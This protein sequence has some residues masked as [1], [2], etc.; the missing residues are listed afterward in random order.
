MNILRLYKCWNS[1]ITVKS[2]V[3]FI[4]A[5]NEQSAKDG[6]ANIKSKE[7]SFHNWLFD[8]TL[9]ELLEENI[10]PRL[11][12]S[13]I[14]GE[15]AFAN[16]VYRTIQ[17]K[18][19]TLEEI[20]VPKNCE[21]IV[22]YPND[23]D[24]KDSVILVS[25]PIDVADTLDYVYSELAY[26]LANEEYYQGHV[27]EYAVNAGLCEGF[28]TDS[29]GM[30]LY[31]EMNEYQPNEW[32]LDMFDGDIREAYKYMDEQFEERVKEFFESE[33]GYS[34]IYLDYMKDKNK[35]DSNLDMDFIRYCAK[36]ELMKD[37][38]IDYEFVQVDNY[39]L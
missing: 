37:K 31:D 16:E 8:T 24:N 3:L 36:Q 23:L 5:E 28:W 12:H 10:D 35:D 27:K 20:H 38:Y 11:F 2:D 25:V 4:W 17:L 21:L 22:C 7:E 6:I 39:D 13:L 1:D 9:S 14:D 33:P 29:D 26:H 32:I 15:Q 18:E 30:Y 19:W 34:Q